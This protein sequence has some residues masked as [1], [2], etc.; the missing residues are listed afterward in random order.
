MWGSQCLA[1]DPLP[2]A[3]KNLGKHLHPNILNFGVLVASLEPW[4]LRPASPWPSSTRSSPRP[5]HDGTP[6]VFHDELSG[7]TVGQQLL[8]HPLQEL[9]LPTRSVLLGIFVLMSQWTD[10]TQFNALLDSS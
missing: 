8:N 4:R 5:T 9:I 2:R 6:R 3:R 7:G 10:P 1:A